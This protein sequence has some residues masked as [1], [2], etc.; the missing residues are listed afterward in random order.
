M[1][2]ERKEGQSYWN[3]MGEVESERNEAADR[4]EPDHLELCKSEWEV[5]IYPK[6]DETPLKSFKQER[7]RIWFIFLKVHLSFCVENSLQRG[8]IESQETSWAVIVVIQE[9]DGEGLEKGNESGKTLDT[10]WSIVIRTCQY[11]DVT[12]EEKREMEDNS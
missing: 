7:N 4:Q 9:R 3:E 2:K 6:C 8:K 12:G 11:L 1:W 5:Q 10:F